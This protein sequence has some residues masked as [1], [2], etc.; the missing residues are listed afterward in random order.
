M[1]IGASVPGQ[2][3]APQPLHLTSGEQRDLVAFL[4][5]LTD[6]V[7]TGFGTAKR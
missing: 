5:T 6:T 7:L 4:G 1:G 2:T 3:L